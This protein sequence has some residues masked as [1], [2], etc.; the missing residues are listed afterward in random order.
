MNNTINIE[1]TQSLNANKCLVKIYKRI[2]HDS[3]TDYEIINTSKISNSESHIDTIDLTFNEHDTVSLIAKTIKAKIKTSLF[4]IHIYFN[5]EINNLERP[6]PYRL[7][8]GLLLWSDPPKKIGQ[9]DL[10]H[11]G[12]LSKLS[13][14]WAGAIPHEVK[15]SHLNKKNPNETLNLIVIVGFDN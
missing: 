10:S 11:I 1:Q 2:R 3:I 9:A 13:K 14:G 8:N 4:Q 5:E 12:F 6:S 15:L 7:L